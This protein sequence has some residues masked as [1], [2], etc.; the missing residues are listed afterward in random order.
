MYETVEIIKE[1]QDNGDLKMRLYVMLSDNK[2]N[3]DY[4]E[5]KGIIKTDRLHVRSFKV[6]GRWGIGIKRS[7]FI[8]AI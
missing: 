8:A 6:Y 3:F 7:L 5:K 4:L 1:L 2:S